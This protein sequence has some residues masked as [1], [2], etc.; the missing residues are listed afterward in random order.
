M[1]K[2]AKAE[3]TSE[4]IARPVIRVGPARWLISEWRRGHDWLVGAMD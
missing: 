1:G 2:Q 3:R 4:E